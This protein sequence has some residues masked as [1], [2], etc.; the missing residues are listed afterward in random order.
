MIEFWLSIA[1]AVGFIVAWIIT[2]LK[3]YDKAEFLPGGVKLWGFVGLGLLA[4]SVILFS[5]AFINAGV[6]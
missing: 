1:F 3:S 6:A 5:V 2:V 4:V